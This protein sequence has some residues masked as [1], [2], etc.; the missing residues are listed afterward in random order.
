MYAVAIRV[1][2]FDVWRFVWRCPDMVI[3][4][5]YSCTLEQKIINYINI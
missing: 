4:Y 5:Y 3:L 1:H 2:T